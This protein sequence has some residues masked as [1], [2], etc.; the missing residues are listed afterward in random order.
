[1]SIQKLLAYVV[2]ALM[3]LAGGSAKGQASTRAPI[4]GA[5]ASFRIVEKQYLFS[6]PATAQGRAG[7][8][9]THAA[10]TAGEVIEV[11]IAVDRLGKRFETSRRTLPMLEAQAIRDSLLHG[12]GPGRRMLRAD[13]GGVV[14]LSVPVFSTLNPPPQQLKHKLP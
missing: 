13:A 7:R 10:A 11:V 12:T 14:V 5:T 9:P 3:A 8:A 4:G 2:A 6:A 1:M